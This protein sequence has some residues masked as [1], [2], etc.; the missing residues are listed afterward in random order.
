MD[1][2]FQSADSCKWLPSRRCAVLELTTLPYRRLCAGHR[3]NVHSM[4]ASYRT[5]FLVWPLDKCDNHI[6]SILA[7]PERIPTRIHSLTLESARL[8]ISSVHNIVK[9]L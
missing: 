8:A 9:W 5:F 1:L 4:V 6:R 3:V 2:E 7:D